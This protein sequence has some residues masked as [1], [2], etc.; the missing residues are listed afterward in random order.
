MSRAPLVVT[1]FAHLR[2]SGSTVI[3]LVMSVVVLVPSVMVLSGDARPAGAAAT[4][5]TAPLPPNAYDQG[6]HDPY[7][8]I[9]STSCTS[10]SWCAA[11]GDYLAS[12]SASSD[13]NISGNSNAFVDI[14]VSGTWTSTE[15]PLPGDAVQPPTFGYAY[16]TGISCWAQGACE[17]VGEYTTSLYQA[18]VA[19]TLNAGVWSVS[20]LPTPSQ[21]ITASAVYVS[22]VSCQSAGS[23]V[24]VGSVEVPNPASINNDTYEGLIETQSSGTWSAGVQ[25]APG[26]VANV[27]EIPGTQGL[28]AVSCASSTSCVAVGNYTVVDSITSQYDDWGW[29]A[30][31]SNGVWSSAQSP[32]PANLYEANGLVMNLYGVSCPSVGNCVAVGFYNGPNSANHLPMIDTLGSSTGL[33]TVTDGVLPS[34]AAIS[35]FGAS[36]NFGKGQLWSSG[37]STSSGTATCLVG[38]EYVQQAFGAPH[39]S[40]ATLGFTN[41]MTNS[42]GVW[43]SPSAAAA[44]PAPSTQALGTESGVSGVTYPSPGQLSY[45]ISCVAVAQCLIGGTYSDIVNGQNGDL[46][47][48]LIATDTITFN[49]EG[50]SAVAQMSGPDGT[51]IT[52]PAAPTYPGHTFDGWFVAPSGGSPLTSPYSLSGSTTLY[53]QW[54]AIPTFTVSFNANG[55]AGSMTPQSSSSAA[56]LKLNSFTRAGYSFAGWNTVA[57]GGGTPYANG[58]S[59]P[60]T[61]SVTLYAQWT[62]IKLPQA[63]LSVTSLNGKVGVPLTLTTSGGSGTGALSFVVLNGTGTGCSVAGAALRATGAGTCLVTATKAGDSQYLAASS[64]ST[65]VLMAPASTVHLPGPVTLTFTGS[66]VHLTTADKAKLVTLA[67]KL[68]AGAHVTITGFAWH[69]HARAIGR[70]HAVAVFLATRLSL[71]VTLKAVT[72]SHSNKAVVVTTAI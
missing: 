67:H 51:T 11:V 42:A 70:A 12:T 16:A 29:I 59:Y 62:F 32:T 22:S 25:V 18:P 17:A 71:H 20:V 27:R 7:A 45:G 47:S 63:A 40:V 39:L 53:A 24:A 33:W 21:W 61:S 43:S 15:L 14:F 28:Y 49:A 9:K 8:E 10:A 38:G 72:T 36:G 3:T 46:I 54:T 60:F 19:W 34:D 26:T 44:Y 6:V 66:S 56:A 31:M 13:N 23:C 5:I 58:A 55:G 48:S 41:T 57:G 4:S 2:R 69:N 35:N 65:P 68:I 50:G 37:C 30:T 52:L 64:A 1:P